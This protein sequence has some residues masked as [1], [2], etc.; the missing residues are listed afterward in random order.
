M[1]QYIYDVTVHVWHHSMGV[2]HH[3]AEELCSAASHLI[4]LQTHPVLWQPQDL[5]TCCFHH[6]RTL[7]IPS[8]K[9]GLIQKQ[10]HRTDLMRFLP[11]SGLIRKSNISRWQWLSTN[12]T[13]SPF[14]I[15]SFHSEYWAWSVRV[16]RPSRI[17]QKIIFQFHSCSSNSQK[18]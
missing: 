10:Q 15:S 4:F 7:T 18:H 6:S 8:P 13:I 14:A 17:L 2:W 1:A 11:P 3:S 16:Q 5:C 12:S 9:L